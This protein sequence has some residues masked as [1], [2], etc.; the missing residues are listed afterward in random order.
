MN[1]SW[2]Y[3]RIQF[4]IWDLNFLKYLNQSDYFQ[5]KFGKVNKFG[6]D[7][8]DIFNISV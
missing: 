3:H 7:Q 5:D 4:G 8:F 1:I 2:W 6:Y